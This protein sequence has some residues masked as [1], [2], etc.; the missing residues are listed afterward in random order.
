MPTCPN[1]GEIVMNG[2]PYCPHCGATFRW[3]ED[4]YEMSYSKRPSRPLIEIRFLDVPIELFYKRLD[5]LHEREHIINGIRKSIDI[6]KA[7]RNT[8]FDLLQGSPGDDIDIQ[9][10]RKNRYFTTTEYIRYD[11]A[12]NGIGGHSFR[13]NFEN[14][15]NADWF[16]TAVRRKEQETGL[17]FHSCG[18]GYDANYDWDK[19]NTFELR[20]GCEVIAH[21][22]ESESSTRG[23]PVDFTNH[24]LKSESKSYDRTS[25]YDLVYD[26]D[27][28]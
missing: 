13:S 22:I 4:E 23:F 18:G 3:V 10:I 25:P 26:Y 7:G 20:E 12:I 24:R 28:A 21:F 5:D 27:W 16:K 2:D 14:L 1:C 19:T 9:F 15:E 17:K 8:T 6:S 11:Y